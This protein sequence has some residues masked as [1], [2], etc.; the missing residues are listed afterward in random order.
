M[1]DYIATEIETIGL[2]PRTER[3]LTEYMTVLSLCGEI[4]S[5]TTEGGSEYRVDAREDRCTCPDHRH[6]DVRCKHQRCVAFAVSERP[7]PADVL[8]VDKQLGDHVNES[9][10]VAVP[11]GGEVLH[12]DT[13]EEDEVD[14]IYHIEPPAQGGTH[15]VRCKGC[16]REVVPVDH[17]LLSY[18]RGCPNKD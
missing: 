14:Y 6:R 3:A 10:H 8:Y 4:Y 2:E 16:G 7:V 13:E 11:D 17:K 5:V 15:Y 1:A 12:D 18:P 9:S